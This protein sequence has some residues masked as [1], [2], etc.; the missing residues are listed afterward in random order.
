[1]STATIP[2]CRAILAAVTA[3]GYRPIYVASCIAAL[4]D[5]DRVPALVELRKACLRRFAGRKASA[6]RLA[7]ADAVKGLELHV[8]AEQ[9][10]AS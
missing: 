1:M 3:L 5:Y 6:D 7:L 8:A 10:K 2:A 4:S 9:G